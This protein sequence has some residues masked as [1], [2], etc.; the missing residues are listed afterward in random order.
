MAGRPPL[1]IG[2]HGK[3][4]TSEV[5][6][7]MIRAYCQYRDL[8]GRTRQVSA[9]GAAKTAAGR[10][11]EKRLA[12]RS[13]NA[14]AE[15]APETKLRVVAEAWYVTV[16]Q[17]V[18]AGRK[19]PTT[20]G[21]YRCFLDRYV[22]PATG[23]LRL[24]EVT[25]GR[26]DAVLQTIKEKSGEPTAK[27]CRT[28]L[29]NILKYAARHDAV[30]TNATRNTQPLSV[31]PRHPPRA[32]TVDECEQ[33]LSQLAADEAAVRHDLPDLTGFML[34]EGCRIGEA[35]ALAWDSVDLV[36]SIVDIDYTLVR[37]KS[38]GL[39]RKKTKSA[40][41]EHTLP[42]PNFVL[43]ILARR[44]TAQFALSTG[45]LP[46]AD[47][48]ASAMVARLGS[49]PVFPDS[50]GGWRDPSNTLR[51]LRA[52]RGDGDLAWV[53]SH[54]F[55]KTALTLLDDAGLPARLIADQAGHS[56]V[57]MTQDVYMARKSV[58]GRTAQTLDRDLGNLFELKS[59]HNGCIDLEDDQARSV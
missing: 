52:A 46:P 33:W 24:R 42:L 6:P 31:K 7:K 9:T 21:Q 2:T 4:R 20:A 16:T 22:L 18:E 26:V 39:V 59:M 29:S 47:M 56:Q 51:A 30:S 44:A 41:G 50:K 57:S 49:A 19:S 55:R 45:C 43:A 40:A 53:T 37:V 28:V 35:L 27:S 5:G 38:R 23:D 58:D 17:A 36:L 8:D 25:T 1:E 34:G 32:L 15:I 14:T 12:Q 54:V 13:S 48:E 10:A 11:L 3:I